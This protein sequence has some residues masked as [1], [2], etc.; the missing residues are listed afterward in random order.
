MNG[1]TNAPWSPSVS[2]GEAEVGQDVRAASDVKSQSL[3]VSKVSF[4]AYDGKRMPANGES[5]C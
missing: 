1:Y 5:K 4:E 3:P 2:K